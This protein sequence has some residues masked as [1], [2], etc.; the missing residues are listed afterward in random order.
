VLI[1]QT[2]LS[3]VTKDRVIHLS[4]D[5]CGLRTTCI[6]GQCCYFVKFKGEVFSFLKRRSMVI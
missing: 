1:G 6:L 3:D 4:V 5:I 2:S